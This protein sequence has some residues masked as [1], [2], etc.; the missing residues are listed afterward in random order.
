MNTI[1]IYSVERETAYGDSV[2]MIVERNCGDC[3]YR[4][5]TNFYKEDDQ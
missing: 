4:R 2:P 5:T 1:E 3:G